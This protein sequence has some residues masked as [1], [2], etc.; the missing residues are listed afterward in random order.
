MGISDI[1][2]AKWIG[3]NERWSVLDVLTR[4]RGKEIIQFICI[5]HFNLQ[6]FWVFKISAKEKIFLVFPMHIQIT[7]QGQIRKIAQTL[8]P[9]RYLKEGRKR[10][11]AIK[12]EQDR[13]KL[14][15]P[16]SYKQSSFSIPIFISRQEGFFTCYDNKCRANFV[17]RIF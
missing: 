3:K 8:P 6:E 7:L 16:S 1:L 5:E 14:P 17:P 2:K 4:K 15:F 11:Y 10:W 13:T 9:K 12:Y